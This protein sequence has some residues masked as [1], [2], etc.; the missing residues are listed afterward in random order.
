MSN[1]SSGSGTGL[2]ELIVLIEKVLGKP[3][4]LRNLPGRPFDIPVSILSNQLAREELKWTP[5][6]SMH[7][8]L[9]HSAEWKLAKLAR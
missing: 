4:E 7:D 5:A 2:N 1:I 9:S 8:G 6:T 3:V